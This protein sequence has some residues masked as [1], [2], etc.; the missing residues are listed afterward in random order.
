MSKKYMILKNDHKDIKH[1]NKTGL[2]IVRL[3]RIIALRDFEIPYVGI[4]R[5]G[6]LGGYVQSEENL[7]QDGSSWIMNT[8]KVFDSANVSG[9]AIVKDDALVFEEAEVK[10]HSVVQNYAR[11]YG[12]ADIRGRSILS[13]RVDVRDNARLNDVV[14]NNSTLVFESAKVENT[15]L[16]DGAM[17]RGTSKVMDSSLMDVSEIDG[18]SIIENC[19][20]KGRSILRD[21]TSKNETFNVEIELNVTTGK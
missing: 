9:N 17:I 19:T 11:V 10:D 1:P 12:S 7:S 5:E 18:N 3:Y 20:L 15:K 16:R 21:Q 14:M 13:D 8:A 4:I 2:N 6:T